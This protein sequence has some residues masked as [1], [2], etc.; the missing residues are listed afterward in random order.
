M[1]LVSQAFDSLER[2]KRNIANVTTDSRLEWANTVNEQ[3][4]DYIIGINMQDYIVDNTIKIV[5]GTA[6]YPRATNFKNRKVPYTGIYETTTGTDYGLLYFD[7]LSNYFTVGLTLTD[8][9]SGATAKIDE[10]HSNY[11]ILSA[12][13]G[14][15][16]DNNPITDE[17][18]G[19]AD[20]N[21]TIETFNRTETFL[22][23]TNYGSSCSGY[24]EEGSNLVFTPMPQQ[25]KIIVDR[26]I[27]LLT[28][29]TAV[30][31]SFVNIPYSEGKYLELLRDMIMIQYEV[32]NRDG[33]SEQQAVIRANAVLNDF[34]SAINTEPRIFI[35]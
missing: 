27:P 34:F 2:V 15:F 16:G 3:I 17:N 6:K 1:I 10:V 4:Y 5:S 20:V 29:I 11:L 32:F 30:T 31:Q 35:L 21:G 18:G 25:D 12:I 23:Y 22:D 7:N 9:T 13:T 33:F 8:G 24:Y 14:T 19:Q 26:Y 28:K